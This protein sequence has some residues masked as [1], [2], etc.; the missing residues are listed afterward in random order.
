MRR[1]VTGEIDYDHAGGT[2]QVR[3]NNGRVSPP[4][5]SEEAATV[6]LHGYKEGLA[7]AQE[8]FWYQVVTS[9]LGIET[10]NNGET[11]DIIVTNHDRVGL[12]SY[13]DLGEPEINVFDAEVVFSASEL[14]LLIAKL[15]EVN[16]AR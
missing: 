14:A 15:K 3:L 8:A 16:N 13:N 1:I 11:W 2:Y 7:D 4:F 12:A 9:R 5:H 6:W 10:N